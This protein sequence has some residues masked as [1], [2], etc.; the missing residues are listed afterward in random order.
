[1]LT[2]KNLEVQINCFITS[3]K[4]NR[5]L[6]KKSL[7]AYRQEERTHILIQKTLSERHESLRRAVFRS[8]H[9][10]ETSYSKRGKTPV[11]P[12]TG[13]HFRYNMV[14]AI[15]IVKKFFQARNV[16]YAVA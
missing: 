13:D 11:I 7:N 8:D 15:D 12:S 5:N 9:Q 1:M 16:R 4:I 6:S 2:K 3:L 10:T 14:P